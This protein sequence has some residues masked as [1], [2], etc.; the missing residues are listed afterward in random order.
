MRKHLYFICPTD[1]LEPLINNTFKQENYYCTS[2]GNSVKFDND[3]VRQID[4][5]IETENIREITFVL[6]SDNRIVIDALG[7]QEFANLHGLDNF[8]YEIAKQKER[9][10]L[11]WKSSDLRIPILSY[12]LNMK[13]KELQPKLSNRFAG[14][15][16]INA[17]IYKRQED[18]FR[19]VCLDFINREFFSLN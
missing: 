3:M 14:Q 2:L 17:K 19:D 4:D 12:Y 10:K 7:N 16:K 6:S 13:V 15:I 1:H 5:L 11:Q 18:I 8:Y 9:L